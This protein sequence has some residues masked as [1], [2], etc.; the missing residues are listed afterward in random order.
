MVS[1]DPNIL[2][3]IINPLLT[4][5]HSGDLPLSDLQ[6]AIS[7]FLSDA[8]ADDEEMEDIFRKLKESAA[9]GQGTKGS[10]SGGAGEGDEEEEHEG[11]GVLEKCV[12]EMN[13]SVGAQKHLSFP[14]SGS[15]ARTRSPGGKK[16]GRGGSSRT[17]GEVTTK[18]SKG[19]EVVG[20]E[21]GRETRSG[22]GSAGSSS[23]QAQRQKQKGKQQEGQGQRGPEIVAISQTSRFHVDTVETL[24]TDIDMKGIQISVG[25]CLLL[26][27]AQLKLFSGVHYGLLGRNG[28]GKSTLLKVMGS[29]QLIG[30]PTNV[31]TLY[32]EQ[33]DEG[34]EADKS[35]VDIV[36]SADWKS[37]RCRQEAEILQ[38]ALED[39][40]P[41]RISTALYR[42]QHQR[43]LD[44]L[45]DARKIAIKRSG[46]RGADARNKL[47]EV[48][49]RLRRF[50][51]GEIKVEDP[52]GTIH[53][54]LDEIYAHL[55][56]YDADAAESKARKILKGLGF[57][58][59]WQNGPLGQLS[60]G[61]RIRVSLAQALFV[62]PDVLLLDEPTNHLDIAAIL[63]LQNYLKSLD[64]T[65]LVIVSHDRA[66]L[67]ATI[68]EIIV[69]RNR[70]LTYF[71]GNYDE[72][73]ENTEERRKRDIRRKEALD[74]KKA[75]IE[76]S[77]QEGLRKAKQSGDD[78]KL[79]MVASRK[80]KLERFGL[81][82]NEKGHRFKLNRDRVG[83]FFSRRD[84]VEI[85]MG[86]AALN[87]DIPEPEPLRHQGA[88]LQME[89][90]SFSYNT[91]QSPSTRS[92]PRPTSPQAGRHL[93]NN[94]TLNVEPGERIGIVGANG[95]GKSTL[96]NLIMGH[97]QPTLGTINHHPQAR[98]GYFAQ[99]HVEHLHS[100]STDSALTYFQ[101]LHPTTKEQDIRAHLGKFGIGGDLILQP[102]SSLSGGQSV[103]V[104][105]AA[106]V[107]E[108][109]HFLV[110]DEPTNHLDMDT[111]EAMAEGLREFGGGVV[112]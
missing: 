103:R 111:I 49:D 82:V 76:K 67:N 8:G 31:R 39:G 5:F 93:L 99:H 17:R 92:S 43:L 45:D 112:V 66:F 51:S 37:V 84:Q 26:E 60:G 18:S 78:K 77:I 50:E 94:V 79:N 87:W 1:L 101:S 90:V 65:T 25:D 53:M 21:E 23:P 70:Q 34:V 89:D 56:L 100:L 102:L 69:F 24:S 7:P 13:C 32:V 42:V 19:G 88:L 71:T 83:H 59:Q 2:S 44:E 108:A 64:S 91:T 105:M 95:E 48:E 80:K 33:L 104:A 15:R 86:D 10:S 16:K 55:N 9:N 29:G 96:T 35:V 62:E 75:H 20:E 27:D 110:L 30:F 85:D 107:F 73:I 98:I 72:Y 41:S 74:K 28:V 106:T 22:T 36:L 6:E 47:N 109:P 12:R 52:R 14:A 54:L 68:D 61:W 3:S 4:E 81:D 97:L 38:K 11:P 46:A 63:W 58:L 40:T 57:S